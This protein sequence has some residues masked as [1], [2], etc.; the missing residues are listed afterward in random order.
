MSSDHKA[1]HPSDATAEAVQAMPNGM[2]LLQTTSSVKADSHMDE[3]KDT[4][5]PP[6]ELDSHSHSD[7]RMSKPRIS[8]ARTVLLTV[9]MLL[10]WFLNTASAASVTLLLPMMGRDLGSNELEIQ[11]VS[12]R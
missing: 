7:E 2:P 11:W 1:G 4:A 8:T 5:G 10:T 3:K 12:A 9:A 6:S